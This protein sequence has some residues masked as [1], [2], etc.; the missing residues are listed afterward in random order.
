M[1]TFCMCAALPLL[2]LV[3]V[4]VARTWKEASRDVE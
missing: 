2:T 3:A 1:L 4:T